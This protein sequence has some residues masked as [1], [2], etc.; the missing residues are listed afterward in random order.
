MQANHTLSTGVNGHELI[1]LE[2]A[3]CEVEHEYGSTCANLYRELKKNNNND[4]SH[5]AAQRRQN[6]GLVLIL[7]GT[8]PYGTL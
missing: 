3:I 2:G 8:V 4:L 1:K 7:H 6:S 5:A